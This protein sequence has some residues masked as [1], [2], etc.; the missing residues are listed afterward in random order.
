MR[1]VNGQVGELFTPA[2]RPPPSSRPDL[3]RSRGGARRL[4]CGYVEGGQGLPDVLQQIRLLLLPGLKDAQLLQEAK[5]HL[6]G[7]FHLRGGKKRM[8]TSGAGT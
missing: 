3:R 8:K 4:R 7:R 1:T 2:S 5:L 6:L